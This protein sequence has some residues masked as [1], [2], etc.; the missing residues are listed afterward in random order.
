MTT[1]ATLDVIAVPPKQLPIEFAD[2]DE[3]RDFLSSAYATLETQHKQH[4]TGWSNDNRYFAIMDEV[5]QMA[6]LKLLEFLNGSQCDDSFELEDT[7]LAISRFDSDEIN[8]IIES[9]QRLMNP[10]EPW[11]GVFLAAWQPYGFDVADVFAAL[12]EA[13]VS[14]VLTDNEGRGGDTPF[15]VFRALKTLLALM[16]YAYKHGFDVLYVV[17]CD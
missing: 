12:E 7:T 3:V 13:D 4:M 9:M 11:F 6:N 14:P 5:C 2:A 8:A 16:E 15:Y 1:D 10:A 17:E